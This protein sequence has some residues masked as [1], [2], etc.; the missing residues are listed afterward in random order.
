MLLLLRSVFNWCHVID[1]QAWLSDRG[2]RID[3]R[4]VGT[5][6]RTRDRHI[7]RR[8]VRSALVLLVV[9]HIATVCLLLLLID[10]ALQLVDFDRFGELVEVAVEVL[11]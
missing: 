6:L 4:H 8:L 7:H 2:V 1:S 11:K 9:L 10:E 5:R 3:A